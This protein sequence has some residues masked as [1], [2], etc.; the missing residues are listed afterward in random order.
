MQWKQRQCYYDRE[1][2]GRSQRHPPPAARTKLRQSRTYKFCAVPSIE[3]HGGWPIDGPLTGVAISGVLW[4]RGSHLQFT[5]RTGSSEKFYCPRTAT[6]GGA[7]AGAAALRGWAGSSKDDAGG[8]LGQMMGCC[9]GSS[10]NYDD[11]NLEDAPTGG[12]T[13]LPPAAKGRGHPSQQTHG[14]RTYESGSSFLQRGK[15]LNVGQLVL[16]K[17]SSVVTISLRGLL[18]DSMGQAHMRPHT[19][20]PPLA[21]PILV[22]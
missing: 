22:P 14:L 21:R 9:A 17:S 1:Q 6:P 8:V 16:L 13:V 12:E 5:V 20:V 4:D 2:R 10:K 3:G 15:R 19:C 7:D 18:K 11:D